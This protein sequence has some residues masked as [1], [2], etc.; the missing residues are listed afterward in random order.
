MKNQE[1]KLHEYQQQSSDLLESISKISEEESLIQKSISDLKQS[2]S[3][4]HSSPPRKLPSL[5]SEQ[6]SVIEVGEENQC[7]LFLHSIERGGRA[8]FRLGSK[9]TGV[10]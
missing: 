6:E 2:L 10:T 1:T 9:R 4:E 3:L 7:F 8:I 5:S